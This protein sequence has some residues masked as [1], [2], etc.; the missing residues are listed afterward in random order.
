M[1]RIFS[2]ENKPFQLGEDFWELLSRWLFA[3]VVNVS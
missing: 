3:A 1:V 2:V